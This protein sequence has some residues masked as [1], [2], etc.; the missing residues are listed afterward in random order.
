MK[1]Y[2]LIIMEPCL[3]LKRNLP[4][5]GIKHWTARLAGKCLTHTELWSPC[6]ASVCA[7]RHYQQCL[8]AVSTAMLKGTGHM[9]AVMQ[10]CAAQNFG[11]ISQCSKALRHFM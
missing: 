8:F 11:P 6:T 5:T 3:H 9:F 1:C 10:G 2:V 4:S 7:L